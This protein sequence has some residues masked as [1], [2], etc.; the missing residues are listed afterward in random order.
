MNNDKIEMSEIDYADWYS[1]IPPM[2]ASGVRYRPDPEN[3]QY[4][5]PSLT[6]GNGESKEQQI[7]KKC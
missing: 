6:F 4:G 7:N 2:V 5:V 3:D 1:D